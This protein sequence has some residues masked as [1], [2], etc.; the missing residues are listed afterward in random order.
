MEIR[1]AIAVFADPCSPELIRRAESLAAE[2]RLPLADPASASRQYDLLL[3]VTQGRLELREGADKRGRSGLAIWAEFA[4]GRV[5]RRADS[6]GFGAAMLRRAVGFKRPPWHV[7]DATAGLARDAFLLAAAGC[8]VTAIERSPIIAALVADGLNRAKWQANGVALAAGVERLRLI[9]A[10][11]RAW[12]AETVSGPVCPGSPDV[13]YLDPM[14]PARGRSALVK[15]EMRLCRRV[16]GDDADAGELLAAARRAAGS[17][18]VVKRPL[19]APPLGG[20]P[21][22]AYR[23]TTIRYDVYLPTGPGR[24]LDAGGK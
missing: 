4:T 10:D 15:K 21:A 7:C 12:L 23:G 24:I 2:L 11:S 13:V 19:A 18:V 9:V 14:F 6:P 1:P 16:A 3:T 5:G 22:Y 20:E 17:R 8:T